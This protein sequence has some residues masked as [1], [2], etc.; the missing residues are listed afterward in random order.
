MEAPTTSRK[1]KRRRWVH[2]V[3]SLFT[4]FFSIY[5]DFS[6]ET[7]INFDDNYQVQKANL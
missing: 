6:L 3:S 4:Y 2:S 5:N 7:R 1:E